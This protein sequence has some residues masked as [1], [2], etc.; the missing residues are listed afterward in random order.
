MAINLPVPIIDFYL[1]P[2]VG[3]LLPILDENGPFSGNSTL[4]QW[5]EGPGPIFTDHA[6]SASYGVMLTLNGVL[7]IKWG[8]T[9]GWSSPDGQ[10]DE[11]QYDPP[12]AQL[13]IQHQFAGGLWV[14]TQLEVVVSPVFSIRW[15]E[16]LPGRIGLK[17]APLLAFDL[18]YFV[19]GIPGP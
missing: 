4:T 3:S 16:A 1:H 18:H 5:R 2:P 7:P 6:V 17:V 19:L 12:F 14:T 13:A 10:S 9:Q 15:T 11:S 8:F